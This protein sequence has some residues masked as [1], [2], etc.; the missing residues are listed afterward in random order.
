MNSSELKLDLFRRIDGLSQVDL[1]KSY[2]KILALLKINK[3]YALSESERNAIE[4]ALNVS[5]YESLSTQEQV[6]AEAK[7]K[8][9]NL[10]FK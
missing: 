9:P 7:Q 10:K 2:E 3:E 1:E 4:E 5:E 8:Y 6:V